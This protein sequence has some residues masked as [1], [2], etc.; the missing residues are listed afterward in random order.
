MY[1][2]S[3]NWLFKKKPLLALDM[4]GNLPKRSNVFQQKSFQRVDSYKIIS[5]IFVTNH[6]KR[7]P[8]TMESSFQENAGGPL[9]PG[10]KPAR[11]I[12]KIKLIRVHSFYSETIIHRA[13]IQASADFGIR[14]SPNTSPVSR[15]WGC[16]WVGEILLNFLLK[17]GK[18][19][20]GYG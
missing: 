11:L 3:Q 17:T 18:T 12:K 13:L 2:I 1:W 4:I 7:D 6:K 9:K 15:R 14:F 19:Q 8:S 5:F 16:L 20:Y 10:A